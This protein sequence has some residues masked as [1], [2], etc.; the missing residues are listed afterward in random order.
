MNI[1]L[2]L[3]KANFQICIDPKPLSQAVP[4]SIFIGGSARSGTTLLQNILCTSKETNPLIPES[5][6]FRFLAESYI[7]IKRHAHKFQRI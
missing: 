4:G 1:N 7:N 3:I 2:N 6:P 5:A